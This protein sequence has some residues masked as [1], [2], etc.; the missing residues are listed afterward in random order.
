MFSKG[1]KDDNKINPFDREIIDNECF[2]RIL[3]T[4]NAIFLY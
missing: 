4:P 1:M 2:Q 3:F